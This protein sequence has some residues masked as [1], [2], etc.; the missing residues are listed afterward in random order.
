[1]E[2]NQEWSTFSRKIKCIIKLRLFFVL[3]CILHITANTNARTTSVSVDI[4]NITQ[5][6]KQISGIVKDVHGIPIIGANVIE[7]GT[8]RGV[9]TDIDG[10]FSLT[11]S[12][13][14]IIQIS[15]IGYMG[16]DIAVGNYSDLSVV[17]KEDLQALNEVVVVGY[18]TQK[19]IN[20]TGAI[21]TIKSDKIARKT[22]NSLAETLAGEVAGMTVTQRSGQPGNPSTEIRIRGVGTWGNAS[23]LVIVDGVPM[24]MSNVMPTDVES[25]TVLKDA[26]SAAIYGSR[27]ANGVILITTKRG[28]KEKVAITYSGNVGVQNPTRLPRMAKSW[29]YAELYNQSMENEGK[30]SS[31][32]PADRIQR[33]KEGGDPDKLE[34]NTDWYDELVNSAIQQSHNVSFQGG[35]NRTS[36]VG[37]LGYF[38]QDGLIETSGYKR[39]NARLN[40]STELTKWMVL[41]MNMSYINDEKSES[42]AGVG[43]AYYQASRALPYMPVKYSDGTWSLSSVATNPVRMATEDYGMQ[44]VKGDKISLLVSPSITPIAGLVIKGTFGYESHSYGHKRFTKTLAYDGFEASG[45]AGSVIVPRNEQYDKWEQYRNY[46]ATAT[47]TYEKNIRKHSIKVLA[48]GSAESYRYRYT[49]A[50][51]KDF[52]NNDFSEIN[53]GDP[54]TA[55]ASGNSSYSSLVSLFGRV[56]YSFADKYLFEA[57]VRYD[58]SSKFVTGN[59]WGVFPSFSLG[60]RLSEEHFFLPLKSYIQN[61]KLRSSWGQLGN[62]QIGDYQGYSTFGAGYSY[63]F[64][65]IVNSGYSETIMGNQLITW[66][67]STNFN[68]GIDLSVI[69]S[70][71]NASF[72]YYRRLTDDILLKLETPALLGIS[73]AMQN[74]GSVENKGWELSLNW[75]DNINDKFNYSIGF[76]LADVRNKVIDLKGYKSPTSG[77]TTRIEGE[78]L[79][80]IYGWKTLGICKDEDQY[81]QYKDQMKSYNANWGIG[82]III[83]DRV[84]D[85]VINATDKT[86]IGNQIPRFTYGLNLACDYKNWDFACFFQGIGK[87]NGYMG[88]DVLEPLGTM[89]ALEDHYEHSFNPKNPDPKA[90]FPRM[91]NSSRHN[92][93]NFSHW[94]QNGAYLRLKNIQVGYTFKFPT[95]GIESLRIGLSGQNLFTLTKFRVFDP[96]SSLNSRSFPNVSVYS[97]SANITF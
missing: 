77:L 88:I 54:N 2:K 84:K 36:Y 93:G 15:Y 82:D 23:P 67:T 31:L 25:I 1:M 21:E 63:M 56:N 46:T 81:N 94:V 74:A 59:Q 33:M 45:Q 47:A 24:D 14:A 76:N 61:L 30:S 39:Y 40:T 95:I 43:S 8:N 97:F 26:A 11:V 28:G 18:G 4:E 90:Y 53:A 64:N 20:L 66:E 13:K 38:M 80:A 27:A 9:I 87:V 22:V 69:D 73:P 72:D 70:K 12:N 96:E 79:D 44:Y 50:S 52:P 35:S 92:Y 57:N 48:G 62:Q 65:G 89:S 5:Q 85:G 32:F 7:K 83:E 10:K 17:L 86:V 49:E 34:G 91:L 75:Q 29:Q 42:A 16:Q 6:S 58:G 37:S 19:K 55:S 60:W 78:P 71:L 51:R 41:D 3:V 68:V